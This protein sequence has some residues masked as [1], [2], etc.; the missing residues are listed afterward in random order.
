MPG[1]S[2][3][4]VL[5]ATVSEVLSTRVVLL[6]ESATHTD[7]REA[8][9]NGAWDMIPKTFTAC[10]ML[11]HL[12]RVAAGYRWSVHCG[13][14]VRSEG[15]RNVYE[16]KATLLT[17]REQ[18]IALLV[19][20]GMSNKEIAHRIEVSAGTVKIHLSNIFQK[21]N[22]SNWTSLAAMALQ[23]ALVPIREPLGGYGVSDMA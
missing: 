16:A 12:R 3:F 17:P 19:S 22:V 15:A 11:D 6:S 10:E 2:G 21:L 7:V 23:G 14:D 18:E 8:L 13:P 5:A 9:R 1:L 20:A 4:Y